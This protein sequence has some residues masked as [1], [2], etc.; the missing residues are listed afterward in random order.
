VAKPDR[1]RAR[2]I[3]KPADLTDEVAEA[4]TS[5]QPIPKYCSDCEY[6][7]PFLLFK[8]LHLGGESDEWVYAVCKN[9][10]GDGLESFCDIERD[11]AYELIEV[12]GV[13]ARHWAPRS[14]FRRIM[15]R[16][17]ACWTLVPPIIMVI[18]TFTFSYSVGTEIFKGVWG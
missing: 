12:C 17:H 9:S 4:L 6:C 7:R 2:F 5:G 3:R 11:P 16:F 14:R 18:T 1:L 10:K 15:D 13:K 8:A